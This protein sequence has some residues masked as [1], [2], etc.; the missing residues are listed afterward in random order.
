MA[1]GSFML[2]RNLRLRAAARGTTRM[3]HQ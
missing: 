1:A 2:H 3:R